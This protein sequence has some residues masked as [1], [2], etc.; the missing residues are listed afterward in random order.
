MKRFVRLFVIR[1]RVWFRVVVSGGL[2]GCDHVRFSF[3]RFIGPWILGL[4]NLGV[5]SVEAKVEGRGGTELEFTFKCLVMFL[6]VI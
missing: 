6:H 4:Q 2:G 5:V 3:N 1:R